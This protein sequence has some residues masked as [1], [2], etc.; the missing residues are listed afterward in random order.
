[1]R[2]GIFIITH[3]G[4]T[5]ALNLAIGNMYEWLDATWNPLAGH[6]EHECRYCYVEAMKTN[7]VLHDKYSGEYRIVEHELKQN[8]YKFGDDITIFVQNMGDLFAKDVPSEYIER[9]LEYCNKFD[10]NTYLFQS[11]NPIR[12]NEF[13]N[14]FPPN[15]I[16]GTTI[17]SDK[18]V[19]GLSKAPNVVQRAKDFMTATIGFKTLLSIEPILDFDMETFVEM[20]KDIEPDVLSIGA[21]SKKT[22]DLD[23]PN[24]VKLL[25]FLHRIDDEFYGKISIKSNLARLIK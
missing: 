20:I 13:K 25:S 2:V 1:M 16:L 18:E 7:P 6:C 4:D 24:R 21:D 10:K 23:E 22:P 19:D 5:M 3:H 12:F 11:K 17:E 15:L 14:K 9:V 8:L